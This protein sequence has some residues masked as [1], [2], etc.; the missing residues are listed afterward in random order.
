MHPE[1]K[2]PSYSIPEVASIIGVT[3]YR[4]HIMIQ[5]GQLKGGKLSPKQKEYLQAEEAF[6]KGKAADI[7]KTMD[8]PTRKIVM[9][10]NLQEYLSR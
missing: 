7:I 6:N 3:R 9:R 5:L 2:K 8:G 4:V 10:E 1:L